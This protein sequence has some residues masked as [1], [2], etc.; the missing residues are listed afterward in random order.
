MVN[1]ENCGNTQSKLRNFNSVILH[2]VILLGRLR[3][4]IIRQV[5]KNR[6]EIKVRKKYERASQQVDYYHI[7]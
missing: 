6:L 3:F 1:I 2:F 5:F 4:K 7:D